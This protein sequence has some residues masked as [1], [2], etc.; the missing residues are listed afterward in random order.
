ME[1]KMIYDGKIKAILNDVNNNRNIAIRR[2]K[3]INPAIRFR[4]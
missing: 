4:S 3:E 2:D 1:R